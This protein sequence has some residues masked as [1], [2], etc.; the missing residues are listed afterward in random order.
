MCIYDNQSLVA[1]AGDT[2][3]APILLDSKSNV[4]LIH[5]SPNS[6]IST[7]RR[8]RTFSQQFSLPHYVTIANLVY[9]TILSIL[10]VQEFAPTSLNC[11]GLDHLFAI[12]KFSREDDISHNTKLFSIYTLNQITQLSQIFLCLL[13]SN[14]NLGISRLASTR[15]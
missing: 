9:T 6:K 5:Q 4:R 13:S 7:P 1:L 11:C 15:L 14:F 2:G 3:N 12:L 10:L 8:N